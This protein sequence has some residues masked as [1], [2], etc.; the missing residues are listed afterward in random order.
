DRAA[1]TLDRALTPVASVN[2]DEARLAEGALVSARIRIAEQTGDTALA[3]QLAERRLATEK[4]GALAAALAMR[5]AEHAA[6]Q[7]DAA[8]AFEALSLAVGSDAGCL[9]A[10]ALQLDMLAGGG[11]PSVFAAQL[12]S[13]AEHLASDNARGRAF[14]LAAYIWAI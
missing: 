13:F 14:L 6:A 3:A 5:I 2:T 10:R 8:K 11:D 4:D 1:A 7:G 9:P 12:E